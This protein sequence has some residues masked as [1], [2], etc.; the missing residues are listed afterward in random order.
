MIGVFRSLK[1][2]LP[3]NQPK[4]RLGTAEVRAGTHFGLFW[5]VPL[6]G[7]GG[8]GGGGPDNHVT[9]DFLLLNQ[10]MVW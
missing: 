2:K 7:R 1:W 6:G 5:G 9:F 4:G 3:L 8:G 10:M